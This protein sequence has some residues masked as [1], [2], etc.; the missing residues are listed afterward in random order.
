MASSKSSQTLYSPTDIVRYISCNHA[1]WLQLRHTIVQDPQQDQD[2][3][4]VLFRIGNDYEKDFLN[5]LNNEFN[6][7]TIIPTDIGLNERHSLTLNSMRNGDEI[8]YQAV[9][10][11]DPIV[12]VADFLIKVNTPSDLGNY[13]YEVTDTKTSR[14]PHPEHIVQISAYSDLLNDVQGIYASNMH[15]QLSNGD[16]HS[17]TVSEFI[18]YYR[19]IKNMFLEYVNSLPEQSYP[20]PCSYCEFCKFK[21]NCDTQ[22]KN[23]DH[24]NLLFDIRKPQ[25][26]RLHDV[27]IDTVSKLANTDS[28]LNVP[29]LNNFGSD[30]VLINRFIS[31]S[32]A[33]LLIGVSSEVEIRME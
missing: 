32:N 25:I 23:D 4:D 13:S 26:K 19:N 6:N 10:I 18:H 11:S 29:S 9:L 20:E 12:G 1:S 17:F 7:V 15:L 27:G 30:F 31:C 14:S 8:I 3:Q 33:L 2:W 28:S 16:L 5:K 22:W 24:L 21:S